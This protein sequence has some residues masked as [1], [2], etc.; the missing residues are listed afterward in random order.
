VELRNSRDLK[1]IKVKAI[2]EHNGYT[3]YKPSLT[4]LLEG[5]GR[6]RGKTN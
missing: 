4:L 6:V 1:A 3:I 5:E 2:K